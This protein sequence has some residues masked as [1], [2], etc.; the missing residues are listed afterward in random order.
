MGIGNCFVKRLSRMSRGKV[1]SC[2]RIKDENERLVLGEDEV[3]EI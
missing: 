1:G 2:S 3:Q